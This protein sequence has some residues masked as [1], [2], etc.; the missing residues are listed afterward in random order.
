V[1]L[2]PRAALVREPSPQLADGQLTFQQRRHVDVEVARDQHARYVQLLRDAGLEIVEAPP[3]P[4]HPD[5]VFVEDAVVVVDDL[6]ILTRSGSPSRRGEEAGFAELLGSRG[7]AVVELTAPGTLDGGDVLQVDETLYVGRTTRTDGAG[8]DELRSFVAPLG[9]TVVPVDVAGA[10]HLKTAVSA[11]PD[12]TLVAR[13]GATDPAAFADRHLVDVMEPSGAN[14]LLLGETVVIAA[15]APRTAELLR[16]RGGE[17]VTVE[18]SE[19][20]KLEA[21]P[22]CLSVLLPR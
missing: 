2:G 8:I 21:G 4:Q 3:A 9:R 20:E 18:I 10:L 14:L 16:H 6:A 13:R 19:L 17:V 22:T 12:G 5:G 11:L 1:T 7:L 15:S